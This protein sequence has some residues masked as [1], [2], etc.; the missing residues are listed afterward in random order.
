MDAAVGTVVRVAEGKGSGVFVMT[1]STM[2][3]RA[4]ILVGVAT[5]SAAHA[6]QTAH[7]AK[8]KMTMLPR[9]ESGQFE[10][11]VS[12]PPFKPKFLF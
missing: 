12:C 10:R 1:C 6:L 2:R 11:R 8:M 7:A 5:G 4:A 9:M 3:V